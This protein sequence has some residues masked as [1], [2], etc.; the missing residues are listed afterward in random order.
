MALTLRPDL[1]APVAATPFSRLLAKS[2]PSFFSHEAHTIWPL[3]RE[4]TH[5]RCQVLNTSVV[6]LPA[7]SV[8]V[9]SVKNSL[10]FCPVNSSTA[11]TA[12][13]HM[14]TPLVRPD[15][16]DCRPSIYI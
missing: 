5:A 9:N 16:H 2:L 3:T 6:S 1:S 13:A 11:A 7:A 8:M 12:L 4:P 15:I 14:V 10:R